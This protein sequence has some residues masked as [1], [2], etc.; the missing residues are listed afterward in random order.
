[1]KKRPLQTFIDWMTE[2]GD[3]SVV[4]LIL[5]F[6]WYSLI[7]GA[8]AMF[9]SPPSTTVFLVILGI[10]AAWGTLKFFTSGTLTKNLDEPK[11]RD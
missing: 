10:G 1:M 5:A 11:D 4:F 7:T 9:N 8:I 2:V 6:I 3:Q